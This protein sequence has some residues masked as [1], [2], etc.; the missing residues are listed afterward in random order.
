[1]RK[2]VN[3]Q[4]CAAEVQHYV[5]Q[6][7]L[8]LRWS[9]TKAEV[10][11]RPAACHTGLVGEPRC[12]G[13]DTSRRLEVQHKSVCLVGSMHIDAFACVHVAYAGLHVRG[14]GLIHSARGPLTAGPSTTDARKDWYSTVSRPYVPSVS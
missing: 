3:Q 4:D 14:L 6:M 10:Y 12:N 5:T 9:T 11:H 2:P 8:L 7:G 13:T 1:M